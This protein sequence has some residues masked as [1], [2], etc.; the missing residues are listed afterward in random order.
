VL[1]S[2]MTLAWR[3]PPRVVWCISVT[4]SLRIPKRDQH[5][6]LRPQL[7]LQVVQSVV[8][9]KMRKEETF[10]FGKTRTIWTTQVVA[11]V[12]A[13]EASKLIQQSHRS[14]AGN[15]E[16]SFESQWWGCCVRKDR[17]AAVAARLRPQI[18]RLSREPP[19]GPLL[20]SD[21]PT[22]WEHLGF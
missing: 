4:V 14:P 5:K 1:K 22:V 10:C 16:G 17:R 13:G 21:F 9:Q 15:S 3:R 2:I 7:A 18:N 20:R 8:A 11:A 6:M 12:A 19:T